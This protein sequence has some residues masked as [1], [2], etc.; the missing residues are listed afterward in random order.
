MLPCFWLC[1]AAIKE[2][3]RGLALS[4]KTDVAYDLHPDLQGLRTYR[5]GT[6]MHMDCINNLF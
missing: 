6:L 3:Y 2:S 4:K 5:L 1:D